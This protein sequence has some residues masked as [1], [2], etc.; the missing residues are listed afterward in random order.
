MTDM[1][2]V[3]LSS[4]AEHDRAPL[5]MLESSGRAFRVNASGARIA[6]AELVE[7]GRDASVIIAGVETYDASTLAQLPRLRCISRLGAGVD[8]IDLQAA[9][10]RGITVCNTPDLPAAAVAELALTMMLALCRNLPRQAAFTRQHVWRRLEAHLLG[11]RTVGIIGLGRIGR[12]VAQLARA[13]DAPV[14]AMDPAPDRRWADE[15]G[16]RIV[17][18]D[19]LLASC[20]IV[21][22]HAAGSAASLRL[23]APEFAR[24]RKGSILIN[25]ARGSMVDESAL[26]EAL[27]SGHLGGAGLDVY[28]TEP[29]TG[30]LCDLD[31][32]VLTP[33]AATLTVETRSAMERESVDNALRFLDGTLPAR[34]QVVR[35]PGI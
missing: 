26:L 3:S 21:S 31:N 13:F 27:R 34:V 23:G 33:H 14:V 32:V 16:I 15:H 1:I 29:Y 19:E 4:F 7:Q 17:S 25:L 11:A 5:S 28:A 20:D 24:M 35:A 10:A 6:P 12:K 30:P 8:A 22:L 2:F 9:R 18:S